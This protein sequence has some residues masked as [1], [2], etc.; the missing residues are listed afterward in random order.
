MSKE[1]STNDI[2]LK[3]R[4]LWKGTIYIGISG[5]YIFLLGMVLMFVGLK[6]A[7]LTFFFIALVQLFRYVA[8]DVDR[9]GWVMENKEISGAQEDTRKYQSKMLFLLFSL[10]QISNL[11]IIYQTY[12]ISTKMWALFAFFGIL[13]IEL[14]FRKIRN[15]NHEIDYELAS[16]GIKDRNPISSGANSPMTHEKNSVKANDKIDNKLETLKSM[17]ENGD[18][19][20]KAYEEVRDRELIKRI[21]DE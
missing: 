21:M 17:V 2:A 20:E 12:V 8:G 3:L 19:T 7:L 15:L 13:A 6:A 4:K 11:V 14:M 10:I 16:Y 1:K 9:L 5:I 18:I